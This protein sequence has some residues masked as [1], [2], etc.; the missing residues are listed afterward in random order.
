LP[1]C[2]LEQFSVLY[3]LAKALGQYSVWYWKNYDDDTVEMA[4]GGARGSSY[5]SFA[6]ASQIT[7]QPSPSAAIEAYIDNEDYS[8]YLVD[9]DKM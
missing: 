7:A 6:P 1:L 9:F 3:F 5:I 2:H 8:F 4:I